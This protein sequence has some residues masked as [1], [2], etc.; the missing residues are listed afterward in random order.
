M[1]K[2]EP[3]SLLEEKG[4][5][6]NT[7][8]EETKTISMEEPQLN[9]NENDSTE[10]INVTIKDDDINSPKS[11]LDSLDLEVPSSYEVEPGDYFSVNLN[12]Y[13]K[14]ENNKYSSLFIHLALVVH[15]H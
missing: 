8:S 3:E 4:I 13:G 5:S 10:S 2:D 7:N 6:E 15:D 14:T 12:S 1:E 11:F 9:T